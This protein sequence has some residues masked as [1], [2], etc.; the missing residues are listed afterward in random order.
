MKNKKSVNIKELISIRMIPNILKS[1]EDAND[2]NELKILEDLLIGSMISS[3]AIVVGI[4]NVINVLSWEG[5]QYEALI[6]PL[7]LLVFGVLIDFISTHVKEN[8]IRVHQMSWCMAAILGD[9]VYIFYAML[10][11]MVWGFVYLFMLI[12]IIRL[13]RIMYRYITASSS[14]IAVSLLYWYEGSKM[15]DTIRGYRIQ[16]AAYVVACIVG[17]LWSKMYAKRFKKSAAQYNEVVEQKLELEA[18]NEEILHIA[19]HDAL[20]GLPNRKSIIEKIDQLIWSTPD[21]KEKFAVVFIDLDGFKDVNDK[22]GHH[23]GDEYL[24]EVG[25]RLEKN[26]AP[27]DVAGRIGGD[28]F[29]LI[30]PNVKGIEAV[31]EYVDGLRQAIHETYYLDKNVVELSASIGITLYPDNGQNTYDLL[32][33]ADMA[34]YSVK[35]RGKNQ[36][37][38]Y[39]TDETD[40]I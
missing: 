19:Y 22:M 7:L 8:R 1:M 13:D 2:E 20:T 32:K 33:T 14:V 21:N 12:S 35:N 4:L 10:G 18:L 11:S 34:M 15:M 24:K 36:V 28:E 27:K 23:L 3:I 37:A 25:R 40:L 31:R 39:T 26:M 6:A 17:F 9:L 16:F 30:I 5:T 38:F 29:A